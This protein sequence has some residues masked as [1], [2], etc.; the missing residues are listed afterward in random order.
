MKCIWFYHLPT[1]LHISPE[2][3]TSWL[4]ILVIQIKC[5]A[6]ILNCVEF[7][8]A[9]HQLFAADLRQQYSMQ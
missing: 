2:K 3:A 7:S 4:L 5:H 9:K 1:Q 8:V 6:S